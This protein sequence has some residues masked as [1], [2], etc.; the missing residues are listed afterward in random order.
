MNVKLDMSK[1]YDRIKWNFLEL[2]LKRLGLNKKLVH[3]IFQCV[4][5]VKYNI[6]H[7]DNDVGCI[8]PSRG[9]RQG[10]PLS[11]Y[12]FI[13][14]AE[15]L[16]VLIHK[17]ESKKWLNVLKSAEKLQQFPTCYLRMI[18]IFTVKRNLKN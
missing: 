13:I 12:L 11:Q 6:I 2:F 16:S 17:Y 14:C 10:D 7:G 3:L 4:R 15:G 8:I 5:I 1:A 9:I 18:A